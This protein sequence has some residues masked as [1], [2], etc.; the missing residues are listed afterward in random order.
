MAD[1]A[2]FC[3]RPG[4]IDYFIPPPFH[5]NTWQCWFAWSKDNL[6]HAPCLNHCALNNDESANLRRGFFPGR[7]HPVP[8]I[9]SFTS[10]DYDG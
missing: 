9:R 6:V 8:S 7:M 2:G 5:P 4:F 3:W 10:K 1:F